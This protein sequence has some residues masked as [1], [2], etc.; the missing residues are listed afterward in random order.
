MREPLL[1]SSATVN[2]QVL[3]GDRHGKPAHLPFEAAA[4]GRLRVVP[5]CVG[6]DLSRLG[7]EQDL[8]LLKRAKLGACR[9]TRPAES[10][11]NYDSGPRQIL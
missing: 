8:M 9:L 4:R 3:C 1:G 5:Y 7:C 11:T 2:R 10:R 6:N